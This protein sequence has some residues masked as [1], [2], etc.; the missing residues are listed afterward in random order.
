ME[1]TCIKK[2]KFIQLDKSIEKTDEKLDN[3]IV[4]AE[5]N[6]N[7]ILNINDKLNNLSSKIEKASFMLVTN[8]IGIIFII[9]TGLSALLFFLITGGK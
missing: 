9:I 6:K 2:E 4:K 5:V 7:N 3:T 1:H 8:L